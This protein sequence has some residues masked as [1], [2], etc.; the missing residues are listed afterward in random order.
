MVLVALGGLIGVLAQRHYRSREAAIRAGA[1]L[2]P[3]ALTAYL[4][5]AV[6]LGAVGAIALVLLSD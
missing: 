4:T 3:S 2:P 6:S 1:V 5:A